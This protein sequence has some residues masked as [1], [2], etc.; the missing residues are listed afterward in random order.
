MVLPVFV[1]LDAAEGWGSRGR[2]VTKSCVVFTQS[3]DSPEP[4]LWWYRTS[5]V[6]MRASPSSEGVSTDCPDSEF[7]NAMK[8]SRYC[9]AKSLAFL[10]AVALCVNV[11]RV[12][13][14]PNDRV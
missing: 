14:M 5:V 6:P 11:L 13:V 10:N 3:T 4:D 12:F 9:F 8:L 7:A 1:G 2:W